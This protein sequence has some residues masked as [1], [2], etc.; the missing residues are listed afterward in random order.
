LRQYLH[1]D[2]AVRAIEL[3]FAA[4]DPRA[5]VFNVSA[6][7]MHSLAEVAT[8]IERVTG[9]LSVSFEESRDLLNY[10]IGRLSI[11]LARE[12]LGY[13]PDV[14]LERGIERYWTSHFAAAPAG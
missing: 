13:A 5:R 11:R 9:R 4:R 6:G 12:E 1:I 7:E 3:A 14:P 2:D 10:R 8:I